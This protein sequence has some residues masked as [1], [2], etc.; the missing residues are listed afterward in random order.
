[1]LDCFKNQLGTGLVSQFTKLGKPYVKGLALRAS[2]QKYKDFP[3][4]LPEKYTQESND[5]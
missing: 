2:D 3:T 5:P 4:I 1:M